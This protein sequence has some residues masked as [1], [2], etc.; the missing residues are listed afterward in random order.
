MMDFSSWIL[1]SFSK[2]LFPQS[3]AQ[4]ILSSDYL[5]KNGPVD[6]TSNQN[7]NISAGDDDKES[8]NSEKIVISKDNKSDEIDIPHVFTNKNPYI[9]G[10]DSSIL[11][12]L[13]YTEFNL[14]EP[15]EMIE[16]YRIA[17][18]TGEI[19]RGGFDNVQARCHPCFGRIKGIDLNS[20][21]LIKIMKYTHI[22]HDE[23]PISILKYQIYIGSRCCYSNIN[24]ILIYAVRCRQ[25]G[26][27]ISNII[28]SEIIQNIKVIRATFALLLF[29]GSWL[30]PV[31]NL[32][33]DV[34]DAIYTHFSMEYIKGRLAEKLNPDTDLY[35]IYKKG[36]I[37][38]EVLDI[39][40]YIF[41]LPKNSTI[42]SGN[43]YE[44]KHVELSIINPFTH[45]VPSY[46]SEC[47]YYKAGYTLYALTQNITG[48]RVNDVLEKYARGRVSDSFWNKFHQKLC[49]YLKDFQHRIELLEYILIHDCYPK[50]IINQE[51]Y[52]LILVCEDDSIMSVLAHEYRAT[53]SLKLGVDITVMATDTINNKR[54]LTKYLND[55]NIQC[56][57]ILFDELKNIQH[58]EH[59]MN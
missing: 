27:D 1:G 43:S 7:K 23:N 10:T 18:M 19:T 21:D 45:A 41:T 39:L 12:L 8:D 15:I 44:D 40:N 14:M 50:I 59:K 42:K 46:D 28:T 58:N 52:P 20:Y 5:D 31:E 13:K 4:S 54:N 49:T 55:N 34:C 24:I 25:L 17:P 48:Y 33:N 6:D 36:D 26:Y 2:Y 30:R 35:E 57:V 32:N 22:K 3:Q 9:H 51:I 37:S 47:S 53:R 16:K 56:R 29:P 38:N 11:E